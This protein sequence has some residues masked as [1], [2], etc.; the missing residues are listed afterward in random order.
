MKYEGEKDYKHGAKENL[1][2]LITNL[3][4][5]DSPRTK[6]LRTYLKEF[7]SDPR[8]IEV[9]KFLWQVILRGIILNLRPKKVAK[10]YKSIWRKEG[11]PLLVM[12]E[13]QKKGIMKILKN[14]KKK[15]KFEI[16]M[17]Y[18]IPSI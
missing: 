13:K 1:G 5:P 7:L 18:G 8:V 15:V 16:G 4:T 9:P 11:G 2:V 12:L 17:R 10:L 3:G 6:E 14:K